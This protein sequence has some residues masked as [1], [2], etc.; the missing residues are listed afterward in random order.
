MMQ[1]TL[2]SI[3]GEIN[4]VYTHTQALIYTTKKGEWMKRTNIY[5][6]DGQ[7][8][9]IAELAKEKEKPSAE[10]LRIVLN[11]GLSLYDMTGLTADIEFVRQ[12]M[13]KKNG[14][15]IDYMAEFVE[16]ARQKAIEYRSNLNNEARI[17]TMQEEQKRLTAVIEAQTVVIKTQTAEQ[18]RLTAVIEKLLNRIKGD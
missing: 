13:I 11:L 16:L 1:I 17:T 10:I 8:K 4:M 3:D 5:L 18:A 9:R 7:I 6:E 15:D 12:R 14:V 2:L